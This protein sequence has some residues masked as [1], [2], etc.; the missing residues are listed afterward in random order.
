MKVLLILMF[1]GAE[2]IKSDNSA[3]RI[4][5]EFRKIIKEDVDRFECQ[6]KVYTDIKDERNRYIEFY[7]DIKIPEQCH[8]AV[9]L[10]KKET[11]EKFVL[12]CCYD[13][14]FGS[15]QWYLKRVEMN[16]EDHRSFDS[17]MKNVGCIES[18]IEESKDKIYQVEL[19]RSQLEIDLR[20]YMRYE[21]YT[22]FELSKLVSDNLENIIDKLEKDLKNLGQDIDNIKKELDDLYETKE[23]L[24]LNII[25]NVK[26]YLNKHMVDD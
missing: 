2:S 19:V 9:R 7:L 13:A 4:L 21:K 10:G 15:L 1:S 25:D 12:K 11:D 24:E 14:I 8:E 16:D 6:L 23:E 26:N 17:M 20:H 22:N 18:Q 3:S 5:K